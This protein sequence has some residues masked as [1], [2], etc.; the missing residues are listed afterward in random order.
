MFENLDLSHALSL[1]WVLLAC[2]RRG[3]HD[4]DGT[5]D[6]KSARTSHDRWL[7]TAA[8]RAH[9]SAS[10]SCQ[11]S[12]RIHAIDGVEQFAYVLGGTL[13][14]DDDLSKPATPEQFGKRRIDA[15]AQV[16]ILKSGQQNGSPV[17]SKSPRHP[18]E[19]LPSH[20]Q[21]GSCTQRRDDQNRLR[22]L[23]ALQNGLQP[24]NPSWGV[25]TLRRRRRRVTLG[26]CRRLLR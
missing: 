16:V 19:L 13:G 22:P 11:D 14:H 6:R 7:A 25:R 5:S 23:E 18:F 20:E 8:L 26:L 17:D 3:E 4:S 21:S 10:A 9:A 2:G 1:K 15:N 12:S 24:K